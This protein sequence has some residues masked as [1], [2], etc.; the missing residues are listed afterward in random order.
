MTLRHA[1]IDYSSISGSESAGMGESG[2][3]AANPDCDF[4][5]SQC[6]RSYVQ[7]HR[8]WARFDNSYVIIMTAAVLPH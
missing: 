3:D 5:G 2:H 4:D 6:L 1:H 8:E 7:A